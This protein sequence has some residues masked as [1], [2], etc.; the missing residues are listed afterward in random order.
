MI[1]GL[2]DWGLAQAVADA[3]R[4]RSRGH[5]IPIA[6]NI[7]AGLLADRDFKK[8]TLAAVEGE[9]SMLCLEITE[10]A[11]IQNPERALEA[12]AEFRA[13]GLKIAIDD[14]GT[15]LSSLSYLK[16]IE[17][18]ELKL[19]KSLVTAVAELARDRLILKSTVD[20][21]HGLG[22]SVVAE[23]VETPETLAALSALGCD[24]IQGWVISKALPLQELMDFLGEQ[25]RQNAA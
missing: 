9:E 6:V 14:Y 21:A 4:L 17:A 18:D 19:D 20:L 5:R 15:G 8:R 10:S 23:G 25:A 7:S 13:V 11:I 22:M 1:R 2:T 3:K 12:I 24:V 16:M